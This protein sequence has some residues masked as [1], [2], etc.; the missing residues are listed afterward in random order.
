MVFRGYD[1]PPGQMAQFIIP[2]SIFCIFFSSLFANLTHI[3][4][5]KF[6]LAESLVI[7]LSATVSSIVVLNWVVYSP[8][9]NF[10]VYN[11]FVAIMLLTLIVFTLKSSGKSFPE[12]R[13]RKKDTGWLTLTGITGGALTAFTGLAGGTEMVHIFNS[14]LHMDIKKVKAISLGMIFFISALLSLQNL[15]IVPPL[16]TSGLQHG[17]I[18]FSAV[19]PLLAG[20]LLGAP[21]GIRPSLKFSSAT[22]A[23]MF[24]FFILVVLS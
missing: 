4:S 13:F 10:L 17:Y 9:F 5:K 19:V 12:R 16:I 1:I 18:I 15:L 11:L 23:C 8:F 21:A 3:Y 2:N 6:Y 14:F 7:G 22:P 24:V 20:V